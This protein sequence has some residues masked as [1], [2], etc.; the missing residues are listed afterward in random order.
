MVTTCDAAASGEG[1]QP[2]QRAGA[3]SGSSLTIDLEWGT[4]RTPARL[5]MRGLLDA[6][7]ESLLSGLLECLLTRRR[8]TVVLDVEGV[9]VGSGGGDALTAAREQ[10]R[11]AGGRLL[12]NCVRAN[13]VRSPVPA[14]VTSDRALCAPSGPEPSPVYRR[15][16]RW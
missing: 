12:L 10:M 5:R 3:W 8:R 14:L 13:S 2:A 1:L 9:V 6:H 11:R 7:T 4:G 16:D 15:R